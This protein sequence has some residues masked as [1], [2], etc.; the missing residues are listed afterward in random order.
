MTCHIYRS[1]LIASRPHEMLFQSMYIDEATLEG[2]T[3]V[4]ARSAKGTGAIRYNNRVLLSVLH[5]E[6]LDACVHGEF[7]GSSVEDSDDISSSG[8]LDDSVKWSGKTVFS[9]KLDD[10]LVVVRT[11]QQFDSCVEGT[12][13]SL[14]KDLYTG[15]IRVERVS[16]EGSSLDSLR[17]NTGGELVGD[18]AEAISFIGFYASGEGELHSSSVA[19][20]NRVLATG[21]L[22][23]SAE[24]TSVT[25]LNVD[26]HFLR[27]V[28]RSLPQVN[29]GIERTSFRLEKHLHAL[30]GRSGERPSLKRAS[31]H[32]DGG[33]SV[34]D[35]LGE[36]HV[37]S[38]GA[39]RGRGRLELPSRRRS[40]HLA[41][42]ATSTVRSNATHSTGAGVQRRRHLHAEGASAG[43]EGGE[44]KEVGGELHV[45]VCKGFGFLLF[46][47]K[48]SK[49]CETAIG[50]LSF[51]NFLWEG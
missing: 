2:G 16:L 13:V 6:G 33:Q 12:S 42:R 29:V 18:T 11:L 50:K 17:R 38:A 43:A 20:S 14:E 21:S 15:D 28:I 30:H 26:T 47:F 27:G 34:P 23:N 24:G 44:S 25:V 19:D 48:A 8:C 4:P 3:A 37:G 39:N 7:N 36:L 41:S 32:S 51:Q 9:V 1:T 31:L 35:V 46:E 40:A 5:K 10:L 49:N 45:D 22:D